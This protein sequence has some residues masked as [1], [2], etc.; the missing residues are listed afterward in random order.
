MA[1]CL[2]AAALAAALTYPFATQMG[3]VGRC[4]NSDGQFSI[5]NVAWVA[6][7]IVA[8][9]SEL[10]NANIFYPHRQTLAFSEHNLAAGVLAVPVYWATRNPYLTLNVVF[11]ATM[12]LSVAGGLLPGPP[13]DGRSARRRS[14]AGICFAFCPYIFGR[15]SHIQLLMTAGL[16]LSLLA[17]HRLAERPTARAGP[18]WDS[19]SRR[20]RRRRV[21]TR[22]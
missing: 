21:T 17:F 3:S 14:I 9:P 22:F 12:V 18:C 5:W 13:S 6:R 11:L 1:V 20:R 8:E 16:P 2:L 19:S 10:F 7:T 4:E 15:T